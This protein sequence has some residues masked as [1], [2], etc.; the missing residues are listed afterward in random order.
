M[1][2]HNWDRTDRAILRKLQDNGRIPNV[3]LAEAVSLSPSSCLR[4]TKTLEAD[5]IIAGY[6][7]EL[8][9]E[10]I[11]LGLTVFISLKVVQ[12]SRETSRLIESALTAIPAVV[13]CYVVSGEADFLVEAVVPSLAAYEQLLLDQI[14]AIE[15]VTDAR[16]TFAIRTVLNRGP[17][18]LDHWA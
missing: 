15:P 14:L 7:A 3:D 1:P 13:A 8:D 6:R 12:H 9:R 4:R 5:G 17:M 16:S 18:P 2:E 11:G 10:R